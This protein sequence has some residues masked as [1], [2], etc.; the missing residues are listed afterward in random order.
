[1]LICKK[2]PDPPG[3]ISL[4][5]LT[6]SRGQNFCLFSNYAELMRWNHVFR[7]KIGNVASLLFAF[8]LCL[9]AYHILLKSLKS[10]VV[11][12]S[13]MKKLLI[14]ILIHVKGKKNR[15]YVSINEN[16]SCHHLYKCFW[17]FFSFFI[18]PGS[19]L[20]G[21]SNLKHIITFFFINCIYL[22]S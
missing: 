11:S 13:L 15:T 17:I 7:T 2:H 8:W 3:L 14:S 22:N 16:L 5:I 21:C 12:C 19:W 9:K 6:G 18:K 4:T 10:L 20:G 1:M